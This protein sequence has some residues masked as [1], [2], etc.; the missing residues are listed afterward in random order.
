MAV[1]LE[2]WAGGL[3]DERASVPSVRIGR[4]WVSAL[5]LIPLAILTLVLGIAV[6]QH[7]RHN[8]WMQDFIA[9]YPGT[10]SSFAPRI[11]TG[12]P[13]W[14]RWQHLFNIVFMMFIIR[15]G[16]QILADHPRLY[17]NSG[18]TP[19][20][21]WF[22]MRGPIPPDRL[23]ATEANKVWTAKDDAVSLP[24]WLGI[25]GFRHSIGLARWW[26]FSFDLLWLLNGAVFYVLLF[27]TGQWQRIVPQ[28]WDVL[29]NAASTMVQYLSL[30]F[31][32]NEGFAAY[33]G[34]QIIAYFSTVFIFAPLAF[35][36]GLLQ[37]PAIAAR[38]GFGAGPMNRQVARTV[39]FTVL[40][41][42]VFFIAVHTIMVFTTGLVGNLNHI[43]FGT[44]TES[45]WA[46]VIYL[47]AM[48]IIA[49]LWLLATPFTMRYPRTVQT[50]GR[51]LVGWIKG[52]MEWTHPKATYSEKDIS[53]YFWANGTLPS[54]DE[55]RHLEA[56]G[57]AEYRLRVGGL[58]E[59]PVD[60]SYADLLAMDKH[61]QITQHYCIQGWSGIAKW[62][63]VRMSDIVDLVKPSPSAQWVVFYSLADGPE[64]G[65]GPYYDCHKI[66]HMREPTTL[67]AY[68][69]NGEP[70]GES[71]G[72]PLR[73]RNEVE[74][75][76]KQVKW[77][78]AI[79]FVESFAH[80]GKGYGG[81]NEDHE[82]FG[83][84]MPI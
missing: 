55:Y 17:L 19:G 22:R 76:F 7:L 67:L 13:A 64:P 43:V 71:H 10:S 59:N 4:R 49:A 5:W 23:A 24:K 39:H 35:V 73:L 14:L 48:A 25:P 31:P 61:E 66:G 32:A 56:G 68:E 69:M 33:N 62:G 54:S 53:P 8:E 84:R 47:I 51:G 27:T 75:G 6:A 52:L 12:Q 83:Y 15:A 37:A 72:A 28:S 60:I 78:G 81:Y 20:T 82:Y 21:A 29:P 16:L 80:V 1:N 30:D 46:L 18:S 63:G 3:P 74:L 2:E 41:W 36:T 44:D 65:A 42:M 38:F 70:L 11:E 9:R 79:E 34:L 40:L 26:H 77:I 57:W 58:V 45:P 50:I